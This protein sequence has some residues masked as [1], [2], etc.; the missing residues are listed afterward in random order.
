MST[1]HILTEEGIDKKLAVH[2]YGRWTFIHELLPAL[3]SAKDAS[4]DAKVMT[5]LNPS[6]H[7]GKINLDDLGLKKDYSIS[8]AAVA[9]S[10][11]NNSMCEVCTPFLS[12]KR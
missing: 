8:G 9:G 7:T 2:Y 3:R 6:F 10:L 4:E 5:I 1:N 12:Y 11:Y